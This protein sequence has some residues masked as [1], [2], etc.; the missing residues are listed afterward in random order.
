MKKAPGLG[1]NML[2]AILVSSYE[3]ERMEGEKL[4]LNIR[5]ELGEEDETKT[6][7]QREIDLEKTLVEMVTDMVAKRL[8]KNDR[9]V[10][11]FS[12]ADIDQIASVLTANI[13]GDLDFDTVERM[14]FE[15]FAK[16]ALKNIYESAR[17]SWERPGKDMYDSY[18][19]W[20]EAILDIA[21]ERGIEATEVLSSQEASDE[22]VRRLRSREEFLAAGKRYQDLFSANM[23]KDLYLE[24]LLALVGEE[25]NEEFRKEIEKEIEE[26]VMPELREH[27][28]KAKAIMGAYFQ[29]E[30]ARIYG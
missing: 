1:R 5:Q 14:Q 29:S 10:A 9:S 13:E 21:D 26:E 27:A 30:A 17:L 4:A 28:E 3:A 15:S 7:T 16:A 6:K 20:L 11:L 24:P 2:K 8:K 18:W 23:L 12:S 22:V 19:D 25:N